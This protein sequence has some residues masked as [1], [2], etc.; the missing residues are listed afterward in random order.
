MIVQEHITINAVPYI[1]TY[2][3]AKRYIIGGNPYGQYIEA[4]DPE[5]LNR[6]YIEGDIILNEEDISS[7][8]ALDIILGS[9]VV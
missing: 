3:D 5:R 7:D 2:S 6:Q 4:I 1:R 8:E 9:V